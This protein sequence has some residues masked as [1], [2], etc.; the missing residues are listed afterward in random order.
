MVLSVARTKLS[1]KPILEIAV[2]GFLFYRE[3]FFDESWHVL[4]K[5]Y[6]LKA[7]FFIV[8]GS[9]AYQNNRTIVYNWNLKELF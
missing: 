1:E 6:T 5:I 4:V 7:E 3:F 9:I 8:L 2:L